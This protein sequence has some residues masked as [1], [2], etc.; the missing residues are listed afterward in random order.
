MHLSE[1][2][3]NILRKRAG[4]RMSAA[5]VA[6]ILRRP[7]IESVERLLF[8]LARDYPSVK[9]EHAGLMNCYWWEAEA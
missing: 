9:A 3:H 2:I 6:K 1:Q 8:R 5:D 7:N 4:K